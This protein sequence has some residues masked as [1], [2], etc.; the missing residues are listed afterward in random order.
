[1]QLINCGFKCQPIYAFYWYTEHLVRG[2]CRRERKRG[3]GGG[4]EVKAEKESADCLPAPSPILGLKVRPMG[5]GGLDWPAHNTP[6]SLSTGA[7]LAMWTVTAGLQCV[8]LK[9]KLYFHS[10]HNQPTWQWDS[11]SHPSYSLAYGTLCLGSQHPSC[12]SPLQPQEQVGY[13]RAGF[14]IKNNNN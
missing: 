11:V 12:Q 9:L 8:Q 10:A 14:L 2:C 13:L 3:G 7:L 1:M 6:Q 5:G 4:G